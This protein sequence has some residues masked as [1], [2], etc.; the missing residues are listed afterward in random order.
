MHRRGTPPPNPEPDG[1]VG[2]LII[3]A[4]LLGGYIVSL[5]LSHFIL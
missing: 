2:L 5:L 4:A 3:I 1:F